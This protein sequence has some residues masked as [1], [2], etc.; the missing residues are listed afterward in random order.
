[1]NDFVLERRAID[2]SLEGEWFALQSEWFRSWFRSREESN[3][4][5]HWERMISP[6]SANDFALQNN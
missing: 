3:W 4:F 5:L 2:V 1:V 6:S